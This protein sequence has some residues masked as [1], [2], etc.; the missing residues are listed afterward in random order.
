MSVLTVLTMLTMLTV[1]TMLST[2]CLRTT[3]ECA[4]AD[5]Q[6]HQAAVG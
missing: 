5:R 6:A 1:L 2:G 4:H 3:T